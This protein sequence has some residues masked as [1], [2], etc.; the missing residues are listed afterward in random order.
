[1][2]P[3]AQPAVSSPSASSSPSAASP[4]VPPPADARAELR[5]IV[6]WILAVVCAGQ[7][8]GRILAVNSVDV[9]AIEKFLQDMNRDV[10]KLTIPKDLP[11]EIEK[12]VRRQKREDWQKQRPF[13]SGNDRSRWGTV[14][15]LVD[16]GTFTID[17]IQSIPNWDTID[18]VK[19]DGHLY[20]SKP[21]LL[22]VIMSGE[23]WLLKKTLGWTLADRPYE[24]GRT[25]LFINQWLPFLLYLWTLAVLVERYGTA[26]FDRVFVFACGALGTL[27]PTFVI[28]IN[29]HIP[30]AIATL[31]AVSA[32]LRIVND[33]SR[34][35][36]DFVQA[37]FFAAFAVANELPA[38]AFLGLLGLLLLWKAPRETLLWGVPAVAIVA[39]AFFGTNY[40]A[41]GTLR[42]AYSMRGDDESTNWYHYTYKRGKREIKSYWYP[43][44]LRGVDRGEPSRAVYAFHSLAGHHGIFSLTPVWLLAVVGMGMLARSPGNPLRWI[45]LTTITLTLVL[46]AFYLS[47]DLI[48][49]NYG[50]TTSGLRWMFWVIPLWLLCMLPA[51]ERIGRTRS[52]RVIAGVLLAL[53]AL[54]AA[55]PTWNPWTQPWLFNWWS[56]AGWI[57]YT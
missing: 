53:S 5:W 12:F 21:P 17:E 22:P 4:V 30:A 44:N 2:D 37:G 1:M 13:L 54:S 47:R 39:A 28:V 20:S 32:A 48:D 52:G 35:P 29:N 10:D 24:V 16:H 31:W 51:A 42:P 50:G 33:G 46:L 8:A 3:A 25:I 49:R 27:L 9:V 15:A 38:L 6:Y 19:H 55:Y 36:L 45:G 56:Y 23:Y 14:R 26:D 11:V 57:S 41:H 43:E 7:M 40:A 34:K 18:M